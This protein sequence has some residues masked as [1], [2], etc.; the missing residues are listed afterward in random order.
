M[1]ATRDIAEFVVSRR[2]SAEDRGLAVAPFVDTIGVMLAGTAEPEAAMLNAWAREE[3]GPGRS[4]VVGLWE[5]AQPSVAAFVNGAYAHLLDYDDVSTVVKGHPSAVLVPAILAAGAAEGA[6][7]SSTLDAYLV[8]LGVAEAVAA[9]LDVGAHYARGWHATSTIGAL[10]ATAGVARLMGL[11][12]TQV[13]HALGM[14]ASFASGSRRNFGTSTKSMHVGRAAQSAVMAGALARKGGTADLNQLESTYGFFELFGPSGQEDAVRRSLE[15]PSVLRDGITVKQYPCCFHTHR[16]VDAALSLHRTTDV[17]E[18]ASVDVTVQ[19]GG[20]SALLYPVP[21]SGME[22]KF[23]GQY[24][25]ATALATGEL[26][27]ADFSDSAVA[28]PGI[29]DLLTR[30]AVSERPDPPAGPREWER[31]FAVVRV[32]LR[33][34]EIREERVDV[35]SGDPRRPVTQAARH[36]KFRQCLDYAGLAGAGDQ[37]LKVTEGLADLDYIGDVL[38]PAFSDA[39]ALDMRR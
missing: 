21:A 37:L 28:R 11:T 25:V 8:G 1:G 5:Q 20:A 15:N 23:S 36:V 35:P 33:S 3:A 26:G 32:H 6:P 38:G 10:A 39:R 12:V 24:C 19:P 17:T 2:F 16:A 31:G 30:I 4:G 7:G 18:V 29:R 14:A 13:R 34:G 9:G 27:L 22:A